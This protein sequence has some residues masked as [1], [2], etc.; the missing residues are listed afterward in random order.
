MYS[1]KVERK[2]TSF[3]DKTGLIDFLYE[4]FTIINRHGKISD[5]WQT[6][7]FLFDES[8][9]ET[10]DEDSFPPI[11]C[12]LEKKGS[13]VSKIELAEIMEAVVKKIKEKY[14]NFAVEKFQLKK[15]NYLPFWDQK[16]SYCHFTEAAKEVS[17]F[18]H[19]A[20]SD[21]DFTPPAIT[22]DIFSITLSEQGLVGGL[23][24]YF[25]Q[26]TRRYQHDLLS[27][28][29]KDSGW[30]PNDS[31]IDPK[32]FLLDLS[33]SPTENTWY[34]FKKKAEEYLKENTV[35][36]I[37]QQMNAFK[38]LSCLAFNGEKK[39]FL[40]EKN[41]NSASWF[42]FKNVAPI[43]IGKDADSIFVLASII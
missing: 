35:Q 10:R 26:E 17:T 7:Q 5:F 1:L 37:D 19:E 28:V 29:E 22:R 25:Y 6:W 42:L 43:K 12:T 30:I 33:F 34:Y 18:N 32:Q 9:F 11:L 31:K 15:D 38:V 40:P 21:F 16:S 27:S 2:K 3:K 20:R 36:N 39:A 14:P 41:I 8:N 4:F 23:T 13:Y 24:E